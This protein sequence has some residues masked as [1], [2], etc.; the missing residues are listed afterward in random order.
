MERTIK[1]KTIKL[2]LLV[3]LTLVVVLFALTS[4]D[5]IDKVIKDE[6]SHVHVEV[7]D[8]AV[9]PT[10]TETGL[11][12]G[13]H[14]SICN[15]VLV[16]QKVIEAFGHTEA[17]SKA[18]ESTCFATGLTEGKYCSICSEV[19]VAQEIV[20]TIAHT[21][22]TVP[23]KAPTCL[24]T[25]L[26]AGKKCS[27]CKQTLVKQ[28]TIE[29]LPH[30]EVTVSGKAPTCSETGLTDGKK[31]SVCETVIV[32][33]ETISTIAHTEVI[34]LG[35]DPTCTEDGLTEGK[36]CSVCDTV[37]VAQETIPAAHTLETDKPINPTC[38]ETGLTIGK[39]CSVCGEVTISQTVIPAKGH[40]YGEWEI[41]VDPTENANGEKRRDCV[42]CEAFETAVVAPLDHDCSK[43]DTVTVDASEPTCTTPG[44][45]AGKKC[46]SCGAFVVEQK[47]IPANGHTEVI[48]KAVPA[49]CTENG[50]KEGKHCSICN[51][52]L[53]EQIV[54]PASHRPVND[55]AVAPTCTTTG[56][57]A[58]THCYTC[59][60]VIDAQTVVPALGHAEVEHKAKDATCTEAGWNAY[61]SCSTCNY[62][63]YEEISALG[64]KLTEHAAKEGTC[65]ELGWDAYVDCSRCDYT[66]FKGATLGHDEMPHQGKEPT[67][68][69]PGYAP[70]VTCSRCDYT[71]YTDLEP[72]KHSYALMP[73]YKK[74]S[75][76]VYMCS[77]CDYIPATVKY[78]DYGADPFDAIKNEKSEYV[79]D[80]SA[81]DS[82]A[83][84]KA[85]MAANCL[86]YPI[87]ANPLEGAVYYIG[88][89]EETITI[90]TDTNWN[91][92]TIVI[93]DSEIYYKD[94]FVINSQTKYYRSVD[95]FTVA[96]T[97][98]KYLNGKSI[99]SN[100]PEGFT[101]T[102]G[103]T[104]IDLDALGI[105]GPCM[106]Y[107]CNDSSEE[108]GYMQR[109]F[110]RYG[111]NADGGDPQQEML[112]VN[113]NGDLFYYDDKGNQVA[114]SVIYTYKKITNLFMY[115]ADETP[116]QV[117]N[118]D[119]ITMVPD[120]RAQAEARGETYDNQYVYYNRGIRVR[121]SNTTITGI[122]HYILGEDLALDNGATNPW[123][124]DQKAYGV[125]YNGFFAFVYSYNVKFQ[126]CEVQGHQ[127]YSFWQGT[128]DGK[129]VYYNTNDSNAKPHGGV[130]DADG[131]V[132]S[133]NEMGSYDICSN[134]TIG[135]QMLNLTQREQ[136]NGN[137]DEVITN[138]FMYHGVMGSYHCRNIYMSE[139]Y[140]DRFDSHKGL[141]NATVEN[142]TLGFDL[143]V[144]GGGDLI[145]T[146]VT[147][148]KGS[149]RVSGT[150]F[151]NLR[152]DYNS[153][154]NGNVIMTNCTMAPGIVNVIGGNW[155]SDYNNGMKNQILTGLTINGLKVQTT[156]GSIF[157]KTCNIY[158][159]NISKTETGVGASNPIY[160]P[161]T[162]YVSGVT[163]EKI[164]GY[165]N[166]IKVNAS[167]NT[168]SIS[169]VTIVS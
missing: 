60:A 84:R 107:V 102:A 101:L 110:K 76:E 16:E 61:V 47:T 153:I 4:C 129:T 159:F 5:M 25:G 20:E 124:K 27:V 145:V 94:T 70:Y 137:T 24:E 13:K 71:T 147:R 54:V 127:A 46:A 97:D 67:C 26:T 14:C 95:V 112:Y 131:T 77:V 58:G 83:I 115:T 148:L 154:F 69:E 98:D 10:C 1:K 21:E 126:N 163:I 151:I 166:K 155:Y 81:D 57:T 130:K 3:G 53:V 169:N 42:N 37:I 45:T 79:Y 52:V 17:I 72:L 55:K 23:E 135:L 142:T 15:E 65:T 36:H 63:T 113:E 111:E 86:G 18:V 43:Y 80:A 48:D 160:Y 165:Y 93:F 32:K 73:Y 66:T 144:I 104:H 114:T 90:K 28:E 39:H 108:S 105:K 6:D 50:L 133:R 35:S 106:L 99:T 116:I 143:L 132:Y 139:C 11:T 78:D 22:I 140:L 157:S 85:H 138:R 7:I 92:S 120:P 150:N 75:V 152:N 40:T 161:T 34:D 59:G 141:H 136:T 51:E 128:K 8:K 19:I 30:T 38:T 118:A 168:S 29:T 49:T 44:L 31:C 162:V 146:N 109:I 103:Q 62:T 91:D 68:T 149:D 125:P 167:A 158:L 100:I 117:G 156:G 121:R 119:I 33:Q 89:L 123:T 56:L 82:E 88:K 87:E 122:D 74:P 2:A 96:P 9:T 12:V 41:T 134:H 64:H 164:S